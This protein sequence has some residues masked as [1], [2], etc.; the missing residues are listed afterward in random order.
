MKMKTDVEKTAELQEGWPEYSKIRFDVAHLVE[1]DGKG[2]G[3]PT[4]LKRKDKGEVFGGF[5][6][7]GGFGKVLTDEEKE[8][9]AARKRRREEKSEEKKKQEEEEEE[10]LIKR[11]NVMDE[12][13]AKQTETG[14]RW[15]HPPEARSI[16]PK[17]AVKFNWDFL[18]EPDNTLGPEGWSA[19]MNDSIEEVMHHYLMSHPDHNPNKFELYDDDPPLVKHAYTIE[20]ENKSEG[21]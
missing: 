5:G 8:K 13:L 3:G 2:D 7:E 18:K 11:S 6:K 1:D 14:W 12:V 19:D 20:I 15:R 9:E 10:F 21:P 17:V 16:I 4:G